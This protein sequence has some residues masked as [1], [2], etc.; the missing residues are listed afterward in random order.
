MSEIARRPVPALKPV[1]P[2]LSAEVRDWVEELRV[3]WAAAG[4]SLNR[5]ACVHPVDKGTVSRYLSGER[6]PRDRWFLDKLLAIQAG[7]GQPVTPQVREHLT[8][9]HMRAL[10]V[11]HP[12]EYR[13]RQVSDE[14]EIAVTGKAE[15]ERYARALEEQLAERNRQVAELDGDKGRLRAAWD[16]DRAAMQADHEQLTREIGELTGQLHLAR[17][18]AAQ[19]ERRCQLLE[20]LLDHLDAHTPA[21]QVGGR[22][23]DR[24]QVSVAASGRLWDELRSLYEAAGSPALATLAALGARQQPPAQVSDSALSDWLNRKSVPAQWNTPVFLAIVAVLQPRAQARS[25]YEPRPA[26]WWQQL[27]GQA[28]DERAAARMRRPPRGPSR[29]DSLTPA[30]MNIAALVEE[31]LS[32]EEIAGRLLVS[33]AAVAAHVSRIRMK[34]G[35]RSRADISREPAP[36]A[37]ART[38]FAREYA[39]RVYAQR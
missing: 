6:V 17:K 25:G 27:L 12:H 4:L 35:V 33:R 38:A 5:F 32:N 34:L 13:V 30:E 19:A 1:D 39:P 8:G 16:A 11:A 15:A 2:G 20:G 23:E 28:Q 31:G 22:E 37:A 24:Q 21:D 14:L 29:W 36:R 26:G 3:V 18:R 7:S 9:L 10:Q